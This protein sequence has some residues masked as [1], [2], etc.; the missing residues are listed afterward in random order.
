[1]RFT[2]LIS[3]TLCLSFVSSLSAQ[4]V[5]KTK[6]DTHDSQ[7]EFGIRIVA[8]GKTTGIVATAPIPIEWPEQQLQQIAIAKSE[9]VERA[10][11][12]ILDKAVKQMTIR[13]KQLKEGETASATLTFDVTKEW[14]QPPEDPSAWKFAKPVP[15]KLRKYLLPSPFIESNSRAIKTFSNEIPINE[16][17]PAWEQVRTIYETV[18]KK[19]KY[20]F[21]PT[22]RTCKE[23]IDRGQGDCEEMTSIFVAICRTRGIPARA[24][25]IPGHTYPEFYLVDKNKE[26]RWFGCQVA[27]DYEFGSMSEDKPILQKGDRFRVP[28]HREMLRYVQPTLT[29]RDTQSPPTIEWI[30]RPI[31]S[32]NATSQ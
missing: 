25:W 31:T 26:G 12:K 13:V 4:S 9:N 16:Q 2:R 17:A 23:A 19:I 21:D 24:V 1:M 27:G 3:L 20:E 29:A 22:I 8:S 28:G 11:F 6:A 7:W 30:M 18:R 5:P 15:R 14:T 32:T 10:T